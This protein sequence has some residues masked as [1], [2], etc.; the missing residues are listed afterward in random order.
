[1]LQIF[2]KLRELDV[3]TVKKGTFCTV[4]FGQEK[5]RVCR[6]RMSQTGPEKIKKSQVF[7]VF[8]ALTVHFRRFMSEIPKYSK[9]KELAMQNVFWKRALQRFALK[10]FEDDSN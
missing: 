1:M 10:T 3:K 4:E 9:T 2:D 7:V 5:N 6:R 8:N